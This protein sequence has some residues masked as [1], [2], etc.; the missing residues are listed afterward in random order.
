MNPEAIMTPGGIADQ[1]SNGL[2]GVAMAFQRAREQRE[3]REQ[4]EIENARSD[5]Y[6]R[7]AQQNAQTGSNNQ[8]FNFARQGR[9]DQA[10]ADSDVLGRHYNEQKA[11]RE[12]GQFEMDQVK[13]AR[14]SGFG[15]GRPLQ[16]G[17]SSL[18]QGIGR[19]SGMPDG[20]DRLAAKM[21]GDLFPEQNRMWR[22]D[23]A[24]KEKEFSLKQD[25]LASK[26]KLAN[27][28]AKYSKHPLFNSIYGAKLK[29][30]K[31]QMSDAEIMATYG[32]PDRMT[33]GMMGLTPDQMTIPADP[34][35]TMRETMEIIDREDAK[36]ASGGQAPPPTA[37][38]AQGPL[39]VGGGQ[40]GAP[41][42]PIAKP[43]SADKF[44]EILNRIPD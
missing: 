39:P 40:L 36:N 2:S 9:L 1:L 43:S 28:K 26:L 25:A 44:L 21:Q 23:E 5:S 10:Q 33:A 22:N 24:L 12:Q 27:D 18:A 29:E 14:E 31:R 7:I 37:L 19:M 6:L 3:R 15:A 20:G 17:M 16:P 4:A 41:P 30:N 8:Q 42:Q 32:H 34:E 13:A 11:A 35:Q 38:G